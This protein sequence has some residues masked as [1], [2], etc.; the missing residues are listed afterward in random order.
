MVA[1]KKLR[2][3]HRLAAPRN[4]A[5]SRIEWAVITTVSTTALGVAAWCAGEAYSSGYWGAVGLTPDT[6]P[7]SAQE[8]AFLGFV[9]NFENWLWLLLF[10]VSLGLYGL[11]ME[12][13]STIKA[14]Q[15]KQ[16]GRLGVWL[17]NRFAR[18]SRHGRVD[19]DTIRTFGVLMLGSLGLG[20]MIVVPLGVWILRAEAEGHALMVRQICQ[21]RKAAVLPT[22]VLLSDGKKLKGKYLARNDKTGILLDRM[23]I[24]GIQ[25]GEKSMIQDTTDVSMVNC[26][27]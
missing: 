10:G 14:Q 20:T 25:L 1:I 17:K 24:Y 21:V 2:P 8:L 23:S 11:L 6:V 7:H 22:T 26:K 19:P 3:N 16:S 9:G 27:P 4:E 13:L 5:V 18:F 15:T 12:F